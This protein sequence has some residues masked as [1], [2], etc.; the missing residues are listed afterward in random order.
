MLYVCFFKVKGIFY[1]F[2]IIDW[3]SFNNIDKY[4]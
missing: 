2:F 1:D 3:Y 4:M